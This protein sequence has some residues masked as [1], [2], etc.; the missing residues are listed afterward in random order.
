MEI[1]RHVLEAQ[2]REVFAG[3]DD[4]VVIQRAFE[5]VGGDFDAREAVV[6]AHAELREAPLAQDALGLLDPRESLVSHF[7]ACRNPR[8]ETRHR[9][10][11]GDRESSGLGDLADLV[12]LDTGLQQR[13]ADLQLLDRAEPRSVALPGIRGVGAVTDRADP[14]LV[15]RV[16]HPSQA[17]R[18]AV[19][20]PIAVVLHEVRVVEFGEFD[21]FVAD[22]DLVRDAP[23]VVEFGVRERLGFGGARDG[24]VAEGVVRERGDDRRVD[25][26]REGDQDA[27]AVGQRIAD[28]VGLG[29]D[30][31]VTN[32]PVASVR[33]GGHTRPS[34]RSRKSALSCEAVWPRRP[35]DTRN[36]MSDGEPTPLRME[37]EAIPGVGEKTAA[38][39][40]EL[41]DAERALREGDVATLASAPGLSEGRAA[42]VARGA[43]RR[44]HDD[45]G[46]FLAT[47]R[48]REVYDDV[49]GLLRER[50]VTDYAA[51]RIETFY[52]TRSASRIDEVR[53][54]VERATDRDADSDVLEALEGVEP[55]APPPTRR[56]RDRCLAT[57][58]AERYAEAEE[59]FPEL[60]VEVV[61][62]ARGLAELARS[63]ATVVALDEQFA[64]VDVEGDVR[65]RPDALAAQAEI[66]PE[67]VLARF[68]ENRDRILAAAEVH[69][70]AGMEP[71]C[72]L[73]ALRD[74]LTRLD[75]DGTVVGDAEL[76]RLSTAVDDLDATVSTAES[77]ANDRLRDAI[78][79]RDVTIEGTDFLSLVEQGARVDSLLDRELADEYDDAVAAAREHLVEALALRPEEADFAERAFPDDPS[80]PVEHQEAVVS[81]LRT[82]LTAGRD[83]RAARLK[84]ELAADLSALREPVET[85][86]RD[87][88]ELDVELAVAR[89][90]A[91]FDC[92]LPA[93]GDTDEGGR[94]GDEDGHGFAIEGGRSPLLDVPF[95]AVDPVD[96]EV[97]GATLL[98]GVN[99]GGKTSTLDLV[100]LVVVLAQMGLPVP[101]ERV[102]LQRFSELHYYA[103]TQGTLDAGAFESTLRDFRGLADGAADRLVLVDEL[104]SIT[105]PGASAKIVAGILEALA[106][107]DAT[108]VFVSHLAGEIREAAD[109]DVAVDGIE[110]LGLEDGELVVNRSPVKDHLARSTPEL[111]VEKLADADES[112]SAFYERLLRKF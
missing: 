85:L 78:R 71:P 22:P 18:P 54:F 60:S 44:R 83:R 59:A 90:A 62:D 41:D 101:A 6:V 84:R 29:G 31:G 40:S 10:L 105:E 47:D 24:V 88:L 3:R 46:G 28:G 27:V 14:E 69:E 1:E 107:Q 94:A 93:F 50:T 89:F 51:R 77:V 65:V 87:A 74:A 43:I 20:A 33:S 48:A 70:T 53:E 109:F 111:I 26:A 61:E 39:L 37:F 80:F 19:V 82:E 25:A 73:A 81:R 34:R 55:L 16:V 42:A 49:L 8:G 66:V 17:H 106:E 11:V 110:A 104:E 72:D 2:I 103:K 52:P 97:A 45:G 36:V 91:D 58:D 92:T 12:L 9:G 98:S 86:V 5:F 75:E 102:E 23:G 56:V 108:A 68:A 35:H 30:V 32:R 63:Y 38:A 13:R 21:D 100:A 95:E 15:G 57:A 79:E 76:D 96:Y 4:E 112:E 7:Q 67:R 99:S 64:G